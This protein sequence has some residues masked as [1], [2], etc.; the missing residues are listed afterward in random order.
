MQRMRDG[1]VTLVIGDRPERLEAAADAL[2][3]EHRARRLSAADAPG[4]LPDLAA[5][6]VAPAWDGRRVPPAIVA[7]PL[8][9]HFV[10]AGRTLQDALG[11]A[12][13][14]GRLHLCD[15]VA[16]LEAES[17]AVQL[18]GRREPF[19]PAA[20]DD[21][22]PSLL[23]R[24]IEHASVVL[25]VGCERVSDAV[26][27][28][29]IAAIETLH[30]A[31]VCADGGA[32]AAP[33]TGAAELGRLGD[34]AAWRRELAGAVPA[35]GRAPERAVVFRDP[36]PFHPGRL[37]ELVAHGLEPERVGCVLRS[38]GF[39][40][41]ASRRGAVDAWSSAGDVMTLTRTPLR[42]GV[43]GA[44]IGQELVLLGLGLDV[45]RIR[46]ALADCLLTDEELLAGPAIWSA[47]DDTLPDV[48]AA[49]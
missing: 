41:I 14:G 44:P 24:Q 11:G 10:A 5:R 34:G 46:S 8:C 6:L 33:C 43:R 49:R 17:L 22:L 26:H 19:G 13:G 1:A 16:V 21:A 35:P 28:D 32:G 25:L 18:L 3:R 37:A 38:K 47:Y 20:L 36:R 7:L 4:A 2:V 48:P 31:V 42:Q 39:V 30:P 29:L 12:A 23:A 9:E 45:D 15:V 40:S 27:R